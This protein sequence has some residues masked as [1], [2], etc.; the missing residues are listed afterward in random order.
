MKKID[1][2]LKRL[3]EL[4]DF[5]R[6]LKTYR[7]KEKTTTGPED[8]S[9]PASTPPEMQDRIGPLPESAEPELDGG[10]PTTPQLQPEASES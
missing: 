8:L 1:R 4:Y 3:S 5:N 2:V 9:T 10:T 7:L 6:K